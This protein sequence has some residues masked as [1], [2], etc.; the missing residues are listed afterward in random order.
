MGQESVGRV[1]AAKRGRWF[2]RA[3]AL[4]LRLW[5][6]LHLKGHWRDRR[7]RRELAFALSEIARFPKHPNAPRHSLP[8]PLIVSLT[9]YPA[10]F[11][12]LHLTL[13]SLLDQTVRPD[14]VILWIAHEDLALVPDAVR[15]L[16]CEWFEIRGC[17]DL[18]SFK[19]I[20]PAL[21]TFPDAF[22][23][24]CDDDVCYADDW[25]ARTVAAYDPAEPTVVCNR[26]HRIRY[27]DRGELAPY[28]E[29]DRNWSDRA[30]AEPRTDLVPT[31]NGGVLYPPGSLPLETLDAGLIAELCATC[32]DTWLYFMWRKAGWKVRR[33]PGPKLRFAEWPGTQSTSLRTLHWSGKKDEHLRDM[34]RHF[35]RP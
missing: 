2:E 5:S 29:W 20:L 7:R 23:L 3:G 31:G 27:T 26:G 16:E 12:T 33:V 4:P 30:A 18:R 35:G 25:L 1:S 14:R 13:K 17:P 22:I 10:R 32:D 28:L 24:I 6:L 15:S 11:D 19:K 21:E 8:G 34:A 9:S